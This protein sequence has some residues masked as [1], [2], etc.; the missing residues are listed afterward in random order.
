LNAVAQPVWFGKSTVLK[1]PS[2]AIWVNHRNRAFN[3]DIILQDESGE[4]DK[5][6]RCPKCEMGVRLAAS[7]YQ[8]IN[9]V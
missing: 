9:K 7:F 4:A 8:Y 2:F 6:L 1:R 3:P 5:R